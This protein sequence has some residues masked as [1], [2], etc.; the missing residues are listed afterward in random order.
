M[1]KIA[2]V[3]T[4]A[5]AP[6]PRVERHARWLVEDGHQVEILAWDRMADRPANE[7]LNGYSIKR[8]SFGKDTGGSSFKTWRTKSKFI[9][10]LKIEA[11]LLILNDTDTGD[12]EFSGKKLLDIHDMAH[13]WP[14]MRGNS[15]VHKLAARNMLKQARRIIS[16][17]DAIIVSAPG[18]CDW[19]ELRDLNPVV[20]MNRRRNQPLKKN[21]QK[22]LGYFGRIRE[23]NS[24][25]FMIQSAKIAGFK[26]IIAGD[27]VA[28][29]SILEEFPELDYR[30]PF[31]QEQLPKLVEEISVMYA[32]YDPNR[33]NIM[34][35][36]IPTKM[37]DAAAFG[38]PSVVN[39]NTPMGD[40]CESEGMGVTAA[41]GNVT[42][43]AEAIGKAHSTQVSYIEG[44]DCES[45]LSVVKK[46]LD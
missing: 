9:S 38:R 25:R 10:N 20:V 13:T 39:S 41:Y 29:D 28:V 16:K 23:I 42:E 24:I 17:S 27:G 36:A 21:Q 46:L 33:G 22:V 2:M 31:D 32:M 26:V 43:I 8:H 19:I 4:N 6:D 11:D 34:Q 1:A 12:V 35:G 40:L 44:N 3:V 14:L 37:L 45:F 30:G 15:F 7:V 5:C 18:F